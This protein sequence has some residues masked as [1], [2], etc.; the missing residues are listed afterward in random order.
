MVRLLLPTPKKCTL[1]FLASQLHCLLEIIPALVKKK[2]IERFH[3]TANKSASIH[4][5]QILFSSNRL[6]SI[7]MTFHTRFEKHLA[8]FSTDNSRISRFSTFYH[9]YNHKASSQN[10]SITLKQISL[11]NSRTSRQPLQKKRSHEQFWE[12]NSQCR[13]LLLQVK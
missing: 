7:S 12:K 4:T 2:S 3:K 11:K 1:C 6:E 8:S 5:N 9:I 10:I 13:E